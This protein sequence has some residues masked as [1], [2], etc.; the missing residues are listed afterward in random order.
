MII[1]KSSY[2]ARQSEKSFPHKSKKKLQIWG[3]EYREDEIIH[4]SW[5]LEGKNQNEMNNKTMNSMNK[6]DSLSQ[7]N[8]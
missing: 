5:S 6:S 7:C 8:N 1:E 4:G 3:L 2:S